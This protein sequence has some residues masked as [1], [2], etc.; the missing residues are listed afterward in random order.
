MAVCRLSKEAVHLQPLSGTSVDGMH[1]SL[2]LSRGNLGKIV[3]TQHLIQTL[4]CRSHFPKTTRKDIVL[5]PSFSLCS[6]VYNRLVTHTHT[7][8]LA[9]STTV[10][11]WKKHTE[12][13]HPVSLSPS[14]VFE[15]RPSRELHGSDLFKRRPH[16]PHY[17]AV[18]QLSGAQSSGQGRHSWSSQSCLRY[19]V[20]ATASSA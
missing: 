10:F 11:C 1:D 5:C 19:V 15:T 16:L 2:P 4:A 8:G 14:L 20:A 13:W 7:K 3:S 9:S 17:I 6:L 18:A 12:N